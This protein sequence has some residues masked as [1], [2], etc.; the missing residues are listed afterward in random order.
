[1]SSPGAHDARWQAVTRYMGVP[2]A[3]GGRPALGTGM[4]GDWGGH[5]G[6]A[7][8]GQL[9]TSPGGNDRRYAGGN[10][11]AEGGNDGVYA[12]GNDGN[13]RGGEGAYGDEEGG[14]GDWG[15]QNDGE[16]GCEPEGE[17]EELEVVQQLRA[18][19][20]ASDAERLRLLDVLLGRGSGE[21]E[22]G[23][24]AAGRP[25]RMWEPRNIVS[26]AAAVN[27]RLEELLASTSDDADLLSVVQDWAGVKAEGPGAE[28]I[29][30][31][32]NDLLARCGQAG[33]VYAGEL[34]AGLQRQLAPEMTDPSAW[35]YVRWRPVAPRC[36]ARGCLR[37]RCRRPPRRCSI[38]TPRWLRRHTRF[39]RLGA[40]RRAAGCWL[41]AG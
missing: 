25:C 24:D 16:E 40:P 30:A 22:G 39:C 32:V 12:G 21:G 28:T 15:N 6:A 1:M 14:D 17:V 2:P 18:Q 27:A 13:E 19:L 34:V 26:E 37:C 20:A 36:A 33:Q 38:T 4:G 8:H 11:G 3:Q 10:D 5:T 35:G 9:A 41:Q 31:M 7:S 23:E 29:A